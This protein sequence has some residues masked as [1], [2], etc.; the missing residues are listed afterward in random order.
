MVMDDTSANAEEQNLWN[1]LPSG[2]VLLVEPDEDIA[3]MLEVRLAR[4]GH[5]VVLARTGQEALRVVLTQD[6]DIALI[7]RKLQDLGALDLMR[8]LQDQFAPFETILMT[9]D[10]TVELFVEGLDAGA[11]DMVI[12]PFANLKLVTCKVDKAVAKVQAERDRNELAKMLHQQ[13]SGISNAPASTPAEEEPMITAIDLNGMSGVDPLTGLP[14][15]QAADERFRVETARALRYDRPL[16]VAL[17]SIDDLD[18]VVGN[19]GHDVA[20]GVIRGIVQIFSGLVRDVDF[21]ARRQGGEFFFLFPETTKDSGYVVIDRIR[22]KLI[23]T[24]FSNFLGDDATGE[25]FRI[26]A[27][28]GLAGLPA[29]TMNAEILRTAAESALSRAKVSGGDQVVRYEASMTRR[30]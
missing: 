8:Q 6:L 30:P 21:I 19:F 29:D 26:S 2:R 28:F 10:P 22:Q 16:C 27:S 18:A 4:E 5:D 23:Q 3:R 12:K 20:D 15:K 7:D 24:S 9:V 1:D 14:N 11:F 25:G 13:T 17:A